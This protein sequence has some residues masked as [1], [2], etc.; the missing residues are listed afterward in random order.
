MVTGHEDEA[1]PCRWDGGCRADDAV[2]GDERA[3]RI[4][5]HAEH[6]QAATGEPG[7]AGPPAPAFASPG[8]EAMPAA[9]G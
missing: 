1:A 2:P 5:C 9:P 3:G 7:G 8:G 4:G 6:G